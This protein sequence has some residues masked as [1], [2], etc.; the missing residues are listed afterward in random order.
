MRR[1]KNA[2]NDIDDANAM[3]LRMQDLQA[4]ACSARFVDESGQTLVCVFASRMFIKSK[5]EPGENAVAKTGRKSAK[6][7]PVRAQRSP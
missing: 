4:D 1:P 3:I 2:P 7:P 5:V 6:K